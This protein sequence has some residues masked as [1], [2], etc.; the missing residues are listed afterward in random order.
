MTICGGG[1]A[2]DG[3]ILMVGVRCSSFLLSSSTARDRI[4]P[5]TTMAPMLMAKAT[6]QTTKRTMMGWERDDDS[7]EDD[8]SCSLPVWKPLTVFVV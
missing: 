1:L 4:H 6:A 5:H 2:G 7:V 8:M 3:L